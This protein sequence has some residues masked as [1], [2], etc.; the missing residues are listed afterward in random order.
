[1][2]TAHAIWSTWKTIVMLGE[3]QLYIFAETDVEN[4]AKISQDVNLIQFRI[5]H[6]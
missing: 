5:G 3:S 2:S 4:A 1:V 6:W